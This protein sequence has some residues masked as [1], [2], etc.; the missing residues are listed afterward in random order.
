[1]TK[2]VRRTRNEV[3]QRGGEMHEHA[4]ELQDE[5]ETEHNQEDQTY[6]TAGQNDRKLQHC[7]QHTQ[8]YAGNL[9]RS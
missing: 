4:E 1:M 8:T 6:K 3:R 5:V 7:S 9:V 2:P